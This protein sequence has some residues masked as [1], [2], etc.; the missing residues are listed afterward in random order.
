MCMSVCVC[1]CVCVCV[2]VCVSVC[3]WVVCNSIRDAAHPRASPVG[4]YPFGLT[5]S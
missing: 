2:C 4:V 3:V 1:A 5:V